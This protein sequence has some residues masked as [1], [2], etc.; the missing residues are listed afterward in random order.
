MPRRRPR[1]AR[2]QQSDSAAVRRQSGRRELTLAHIEALLVQ[3]RAM[4]RVDARHIFGQLGR[5]AGASVRRTAVAVPAE[6][7]HAAGGAMVMDRRNLLIAMMAMVIAVLFWA[8]I[9]WAR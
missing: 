6:Q 2:A 9:G 7:A 3:R 8:L 1:A 5:A 4:A